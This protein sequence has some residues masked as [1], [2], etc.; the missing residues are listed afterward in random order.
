MLTEPP[1]KKNLTPGPAGTLCELKEGLI[2][3]GEKYTM[4]DFASGLKSDSLYLSGNAKWRDAFTSIDKAI[5]IKGP[6]L[7]AGNAGYRNHYHWLAQIWLSALHIRHNVESPNELT[8]I[9]QALSAERKEFLVH[10][11]ITRIIEIPPRC[12]CYFENALLSDIAYGSA[13]FASSSQASSLPDQIELPELIQQ[14][15]F[16][17]ISRKDSVYR[18]VTN[19]EETSH[20]LNELGFETVCL[21]DLPI[22]EQASLFRHAKFIVAP[23][24]AGLANL[25]FARGQ[26]NLIELLPEDYPNPCYYAIAKQRSLC[27]DYQMCSVTN[28]GAAHHH[29]KMTVDVSALV[30]KVA[31]ALKSAKFSDEQTYQ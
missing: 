13:T 31:S 9:S 11:G 21:S 29:S 4:I 16:L 18:P 24:G 3:S 7:L 22:S 26:A 5:A 15:P 28:D 27:Y 17:Y 2:L 12:A 10:C 19:E 1:F 20:A 8:F 30:N 6:A 25:I 23:H 14:H